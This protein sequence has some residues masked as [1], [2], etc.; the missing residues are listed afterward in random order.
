M[1]VKL[2]ALAV[3]VIARVLGSALA[4]TLVSLLVVLYKHYVGEESHGLQKG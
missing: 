4:F 2:L 3:L 1:F